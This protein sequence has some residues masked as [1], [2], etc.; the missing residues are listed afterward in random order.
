MTSAQRQNPGPPLEAAGRGIENDGGTESVPGAESNGVTTH[1]IPGPIRTA[2]NQTHVARDLTDAP[3]IS[4]VYGAL[5]AEPVF[6][7]L[8]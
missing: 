3:R 7:L 8:Y 2:R 5:E 1:Q 6:V 4:I